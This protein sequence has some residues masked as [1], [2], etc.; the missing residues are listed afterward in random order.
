MRGK[1]VIFFLYKFYNC[2]EYEDLL[3]YSNLCWLCRGHVLSRF[4]CR[5]EPIKEFLDK[6]TEKLSKLK[7]ENWLLKFMFLTE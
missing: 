5:F 6:K 1:N 7:D 4:V 3:L 2:L